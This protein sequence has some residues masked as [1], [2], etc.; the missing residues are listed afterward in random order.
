MRQKIEGAAVR[1]PSVAAV[2]AEP[3]TPQLGSAGRARPKAFPEALPAID[4]HPNP[5]PSPNP[6]QNP[7][8]NPNPNPFPNP[9]P[10]PNPKQAL[11]A[12]GLEGAS[13]R[14]LVKG[15]T[16]SLARRVDGT[17]QD[18]TLRAVGHLV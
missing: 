4:S 3:K 11:P 10:N 14:L 7:N 8:R 13:C 6:N 12:I 5:S 18:P 16:Y 17:L 1:L 9:N 2:L 15:D